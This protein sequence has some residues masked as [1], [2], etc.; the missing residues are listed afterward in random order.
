MS[1]A[2]G[3]PSRS[4]AVW[5]SSASQSASFSALLELSL[6]VT[7]TETLFQALPAFPLL[8]L[9]SSARPEHRLETFGTRTDTV[10]AVGCG[11]ASMVTELVAYAQMW[12]LSWI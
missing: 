5:Y 9:R 12:Q 3:R 11:G 2:F 8:P 6:V 1:T 4:S 7:R 10:G